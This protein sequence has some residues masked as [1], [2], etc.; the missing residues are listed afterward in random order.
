IVPIGSSVLHQ[1]ARDHA[2][3][4]P[5]S[6]NGAFTISV[7]LSAHQLRHPGLIDEV[8]GVL[9]HHGLEASSLCLE[10]T[11]ARYW[12]TSTAT[13]GSWWGCAASASASP[14]TISGRDTPLS[15]T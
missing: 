4:K 1:A 2:Q 10:L 11:E 6:P 3:W 9:D 13:S 5:A 15:P 12:R 8:R 7:N 14:S